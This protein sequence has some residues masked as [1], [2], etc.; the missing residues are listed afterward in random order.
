MQLELTSKLYNFKE[1]K[2]KI[3]FKEFLTLQGYVPNKKGHT[4]SEFAQKLNISVGYVSKLYNNRTSTFTSK[5]WNDLRIYA[6]SLGYELINPKD[7]Y[8]NI[9]LERKV[10]SLEEENAALKDEIISLKSELLSYRKLKKYAEKICR[11]EV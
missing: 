3:T 5:K 11:K 6:K 8:T 2:M 9:P 4:L 10:K 1:T 7:T